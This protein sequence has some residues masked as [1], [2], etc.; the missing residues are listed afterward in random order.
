[1]RFFRLSTALAV[2]GLAGLAAAQQ[3]FATV[4]HIRG[5]I[6]SYTCPPAPLF[7]TR[8][9]HPGI[10]LQHLRAKLRSGTTQDIYKLSWPLGGRHVRLAAEALNQPSSHG[11]INLGTI[12]NWASQSAGPGLVAALN[13]DFFTSVGWSSGHP[14]GMLVQSRH[15]V[16]FG[17]GDAGVGYEPNGRMVMGEPTA[18]PAKFLLPNGKTATIESF[19]SGSSELR[20]VHGD[21]VIVK[22]AGGS[23]TQPNVPSGFTGFIVGSAQAPNPFPNMLRGSQTVAN[24][25]GGSSRETVAGF[26]FGD[27]GG[28]ITTASLPISLATGP[29]TLAAGQA[30]VI[31]HTSTPNLAYAGLYRLATHSHVVRITVDAEAWSHVTDVMGGKPQLVKNGTV[32]YPT[33]W[34]DPPM[35]SGD[36]WQWEYPHWRPALAETKTRGW[37]IITGGVHY[38]N[39]VYGWNWGK[40]LVQLG[41]EN[42]MGFDNNSSTELYAPGNGTWTFSPGWERPITEA[43]ALFYR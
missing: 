24:P 37:M 4:P 32:E 12:S 22:T 5:P 17:T 8:T 7:C 27:G 28:V 39:G 26:R 23:G 20:N 38:G 40:M 6:A 14:S 43:T 42:A 18:K 30:L 31:A 36:G 35:M 19:D 33:A 13:G 41:A 11:D 16:A 10:T 3:A 25:T 9:L 15:V 34:Q 2:A 1:L 21:Q 29:V